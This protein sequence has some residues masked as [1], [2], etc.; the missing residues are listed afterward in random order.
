MFEEHPEEKKNIPF[1]VSF[2][3]HRAQVNWFEKQFSQLIDRRNPTLPIGTLLIMADFSESP[4][5]QHKDKTSD[6]IYCKQSVLLGPTPCLFTVS[7][8]KGGLAIILVEVNFFAM[9]QRTPA[10][11]FCKFLK[12]HFCT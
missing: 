8:G 6:F 7:D 10:N 9:T 4:S 2:L 5:F 3:H 12:K 1:A 11:E